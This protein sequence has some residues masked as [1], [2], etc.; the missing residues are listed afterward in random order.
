M[1]INETINISSQFF[2]LDK[3]DNIDDIVNEISNSDKNHIN[4]Y[5]LGKQSY[6]PIWELQKKIQKSFFI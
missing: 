1:M 5:W 4:F 3:L 6:N 2:N